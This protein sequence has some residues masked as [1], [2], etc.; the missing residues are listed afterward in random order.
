M[1]NLLVGGITIAAAALSV[2][3]C[4][5]STP[6]VGSNS[7]TSDVQT[8]PALITTGGPSG[9]GP[10]QEICKV[11][12]SGGSY[13]LYVTSKT[14]NNLTACGG[15]TPFKGTIDNLLNL[16]NM[17]RRCILPTVGGTGTTPTSNA[18]VGVYSDTTQSGLSA[19]NNYCEA[20]GGTNN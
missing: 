1:K 15:G 8:T 18:I 2:T 20:N 14:L 7:A 9:M 13:Y 3:G 12:E 16:P 17:D 6:A 4:S 10:G 5:N 19:A 11:D